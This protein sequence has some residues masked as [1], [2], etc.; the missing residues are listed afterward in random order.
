MF[1]IF[2]LVK[3]K[4]RVGYAV[5]LG[6]QLQ[7]KT[8]GTGSIYDPGLQTL[9]FHSKIISFTVNFIFWHKLK[10]FLRLKEVQMCWLIVSKIQFK[11]E[12][13]KKSQLL[14]SNFW[15]NKTISAQM[16]HPIPFEAYLWLSLYQA[17]RP[18]H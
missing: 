1:D 8:R 2:E 14:K 6:N 3:R 12:L 7:E 4:C 18:P 5:V 11:P 16:F 10:L 13:L 17:L 9:L 15:K